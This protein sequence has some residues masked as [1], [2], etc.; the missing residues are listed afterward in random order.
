[1]PHIGLDAL[2]QLGLD[3][4]FVQMNGSLS[5]HSHTSIGLH[6]Q[7]QPAT[8][9]KILRVLSGALWDVIVDLRPDRQAICNGWDLSSVLQT[10]RFWS[11]R[12]DVHTDFNPWA[13]H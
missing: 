6:M 4:Q 10:V 11:F 3:F 8:E 9:T 13:Q 12:Q 7:R 5:T 2:E 1:M